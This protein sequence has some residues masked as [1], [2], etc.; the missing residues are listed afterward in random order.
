[1]LGESVTHIVCGLCDYDLPVIICVAYLRF[2]ESPVMLRCYPQG[3]C[4]LGVGLDVLVCRHT[5]CYPQ[6]LCRL[7]VGLDVLVCRQIRFSRRDLIG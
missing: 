4:R 5:R 7:G 2:P 6:G 3:L 1:M